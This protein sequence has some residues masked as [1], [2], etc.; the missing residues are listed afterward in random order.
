MSRRSRRLALA[1][2]APL[3][4]TALAACGDDSG[5]DDPAGAGL[6]SLTVEGDVGSS[7]EVTFDGQVSVSETETETLITGEGERDRGR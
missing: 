3:L 6:E 5:G 2:V 4:L 1:L 7:P